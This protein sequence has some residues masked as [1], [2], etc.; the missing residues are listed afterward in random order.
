MKIRRS[1]SILLCASWSCVGC[2]ALTLAAGSG[3][4]G[5]DSGGG[6]PPSGGSLTLNSALPTGG[7][8]SISALGYSLVGPSGNINPADLNSGLTLGGPINVLATQQGGSISIIDSSLLLTGGALAPSSQSLSINASG[9]ING[10]SLS[11]IASGTGGSLNLNASSFSSSISFTGSINTTSGS[12]ANGGSVNLNAFTDLL[13]TG[14]INASSTGSGNGGSIQL[15]ST[16]GN[17]GGGAINASATSGLLGGNVQI[18]TS[19]NITLLDLNTSTLGTNASTGASGSAGNISLSTAEFISTGSIN[20]TSP[21]PGNGGNVSL[22]ATGPYV[23]TSAINASGSINISAGTNITTGNIN[24]FGTSVPASGPNTGNVSLIASG[25]IS[26]GGINTGASNTPGD[27]KGGNISIQ[28]GGVAQFGP[29]FTGSSASNG[30]GGSVTVAATGGILGSG[31][32]INT[33]GVANSGSISLVTQGSILVVGDLN[34]SVP[35]TVTFTG[36]IPPPESYIVGGEFFQLTQTFTGTIPPPEP[37]I[38]VGG[39]V[40]LGGRFGARQAVTSNTAS[41]GLSV[42]STFG[43]ISGGSVFVQQTVSGNI[44]LSGISVSNTFGNVQG[45][46]INIQQ[47]ISSNTAS[48]GTGISNSISGNSITGGGSIN[49]QQSIT[50]N[51]AQ[52]TQVNSNSISANSI[53]AGRSVD[54]TQSIQNNIAGG[55]F[56]INIT[57]GPVTSQGNV[58]ITQDIGGNSAPAGGKTN[59]GLCSVSANGSIRIQQNINGNTPTANSGNISFNSLSGSDI[60][61]TQ[62]SVEA[63]DFLLSGG[64]ISASGD[65]SI[66]QS[67]NPIGSVSD[68]KLPSLNI[69]SIV[70]TKENASISVTQTGATASRP[71]NFGSIRAGSGSRVSLA[72]DG[73][74]SV[75]TIDFEPPASGTATGSVDIKAD[76]FDSYRFVLTGRSNID[77]SIK[78]LTPDRDINIGSVP[79][80]QALNLPDL[81]AF[82]PGVTRLSIGSQGSQGKVFITSSLTL[83]SPT[84]FLGGVGLSPGVVVRMPVVSPTTTR[85]GAKTVFTDLSGSGLVVGAPGVVSPVDIT[86]TFTPGQ[87]SFADV[88]LNFQPGSSLMFNLNPEQSPLSPAPVIIRR[89]YVNIEGISVIVGLKL[90]FPLRSLGLPFASSSSTGTLQ[91]PPQGTTY[92]LIDLGED[93]TLSGTFLDLPQGAIFD[94]MEGIPLQ[95]DYTNGVRV[96]VV[97]EHSALSLLIPF[98]PVFVR[99]RR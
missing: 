27:A 83:S 6:R 76:R 2:P 86:G 31:S 95:I 4:P 14:G 15:F 12:N 69:G 71:L 59:I 23:V 55:Q 65:I 8:I 41:S 92:T 94:S 47:S 75:G 3:P 91:F 50:G 89:S 43:N 58:R 49:I 46:N 53:R 45:G 63:V 74:L 73:L 21:Q 67:R 60:T 82:G 98:A 9:P 11:L 85:N 84:T 52:G 66:T 93:S 17:I 35:P 80:P 13:V 18:N 10:G 20:A 22:N 70:T 39:D 77:L 30:A 34:G 25:D 90:S 1:F 33:S 57:V 68:I 28:A 26:T 79:L 87:C 16:S 78:G 24:T 32:S 51:T 48:G 42:S 97:P 61:I 38:M 37:V 56:N 88:D 5:S 96:T 40:S 81:T 29:I 99:R 36:T 7:A 64:L 44:A 72:T 19:G 62:T 54:I